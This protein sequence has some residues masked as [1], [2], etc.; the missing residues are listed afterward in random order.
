M[1]INENAVSGPPK[2]DPSERPSKAVAVARQRQS[3][4]APAFRLGLT[5]TDDPCAMAIAS[6]HSDEQGWQAR[7]LET[8]GTTS[9]DFV[10]TQ[11]ARIGELFRDKSGR[12]DIDAVEAVIAV[13]DG[14][15]PRNE[16]EAML[17]TQ[18]ATTHALILK[19]MRRLQ[20]VDTIQQND[21]AS[22]TLA[23]LQRTFTIQVETLASL[24]RG[25]RQKVTVEHVHV[26]P[27]GQAIVGDVTTGGPGE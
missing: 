12:M 14:A 16:I 27:G 8:F 15:R 2:K 17:I 13:L 5:A 4:R 9:S 21:S 23:R 24:R 20:T 1:P 26:Y 22:V 19:L 25:G 18:M 11:L 3:E 10:A 6:P 7:L